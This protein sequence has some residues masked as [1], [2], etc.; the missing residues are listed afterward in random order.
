MGADQTTADAAANSASAKSED[1]ESIWGAM[2]RLVGNH[3][4]ATTDASDEYPDQAKDIS[5]TAK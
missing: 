1:H 4:K 3:K 2:T 5:G